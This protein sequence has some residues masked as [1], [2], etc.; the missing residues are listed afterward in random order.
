[1]V[2]V[3][4]RSMGEEVRIMGKLGRSLR[5]KVL[6]GAY[7]K[8]ARSA[9]AKGLANA[10]APGGRAAAKS[11]LGGL[12]IRG[13][14]AWFGAPQLDAPFPDVLH[15]GVQ[16]KRDSHRNGSLGQPG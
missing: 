6:N 3:M 7:H 4:G 15:L 5:T 2:V 10:F 9:R 12:G 14:S 13:S 1:M 11:T 16:L 8:V